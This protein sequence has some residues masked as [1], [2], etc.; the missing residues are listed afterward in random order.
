MA[1]APIK[2]TSA[3][4]E[5]TYAAVASSPTLLATVA[6]PSSAA[7]ATRGRWGFKNPRRRRKALTPAHHRRC[8]RGGRRGR[9]GGAVLDAYRPRRDGPPRALLSDPPRRRYSDGGR[10]R[11]RYGP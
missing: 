8:S 9:R 10:L 5:I 1:R 4:A 11:G 7:S 3:A 6:T 2:D